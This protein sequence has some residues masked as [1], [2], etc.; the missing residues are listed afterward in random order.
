MRLVILV[1][2]VLGDALLEP[3]QHVREV[4]LVGFR[5]T[6]IGHHPRRPGRLVF[7]QPVGKVDE[8]L[9]AP[10]VDMLG[11]RARGALRLGPLRLGTP[12]LMTHWLGSPRLWLLLRACGIPFGCW[13]RFRH[14]RTR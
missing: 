12:R 8:I 11:D 14:L 6:H 2:Y 9:I 4:H 10:A 1:G 7:A 3:F 13:R 5:L